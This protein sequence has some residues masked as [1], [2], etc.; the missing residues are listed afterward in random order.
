M[1]SY[2]IKYSSYFILIGSILL[3]MY[4]LD[5]VPN[6]LRRASDT[7]RLFFPFIFV[8]LGLIGK[9]LSK[10]NSNEIKSGNYIENFK[11]EDNNI[12]QNHS[13]FQNIIM[14][15]IDNEI[16]NQKKSNENKNNSS[17]SEWLKKN[18]GKSLNDYYKWL[19]NY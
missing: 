12:K 1:K 17:P 6:R 9:L 2:F 18:S 15:P 16:P 3:L 5:I 4:F 8:I 11:N 14:E 19:N 13:E 7:Q 10:E